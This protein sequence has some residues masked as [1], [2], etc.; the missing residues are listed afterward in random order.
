MNMSTKVNIEFMEE[1][2]LEKALSRCRRIKRCQQRDSR[3]KW[4]ESL[5]K[6]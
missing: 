1:I 3:D 2:R 6:L 5:E 4:D